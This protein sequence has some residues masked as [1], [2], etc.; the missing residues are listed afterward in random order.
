MNM[1]TRWYIP[2]PFVFCSF[3]LTALGSAAC[4]ETT[5]QA[6]ILPSRDM[7][8][9]EVPLR[10]SPELRAAV[11]ANVTFVGF[12]MEIGASV[13]TTASDPETA[14]DAFSG[15]QVAQEFSQPSPGQYQPIDEL[16]VLMKRD[17]SLPFTQFAGLPVVD[18]YEEGH[19]I[20]LSSKGG[21]SPEVL[22]KISLEP[23]VRY[24]EPSFPFGTL[25][26]TPNDPDFGL[27][28]SW[29]LLNIRA[30]KAWDK[31]HDVPA[32]VVG[33]VDT[34]IYYDHVDLKDNIWSNAQ[35]KHGYDFADDDDD[36]KDFLGHGTHC[37]GVIAAVG[38]NSKGT[39]GVSWKLQLMALK[40]FHND[41]RPIGNVA[42]SQY[43]AK[44]LDYGV[45]NGAMIIN[46]SVGGP[47]DAQVLKEAIARTESAHV[48]VVAACGNK[49]K[50]IEVFPHTYP[51]YYSNPNILSVAA[52]EKDGNGEKIYVL[53]NYGKF[54]VDIA[55]PGHNIW[56]T[57]PPPELYGL[58]SG[59]SMSAAFVSGSSA[60]AWVGC[61]QPR[62]LCVK[63]KLEDNARDSKTLKGKCRKESTLDIEFLGN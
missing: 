22:R 21:F 38:H 10:L 23:S 36:P 52:V 61:T 62:D 28:G 49:T 48:L 31:I 34:G 51:A 15:F 58:K 1:I 46:C 29:G 18:R 3:L 4:A 6:V 13:F 57:L 59:T 41:D 25:D 30:P 26:T 63:K 9:E 40:V 27:D 55:A 44:A 43:L 47:Y 12:N 33:V 11:F 20:V 32:V 17:A 19:F 16:V 42:M 14:L 60:L 53:S 39:V 50:D 24:V 8:S 37:A 56:S 5:I 54:S 2:R 45:K 7:L 35:G